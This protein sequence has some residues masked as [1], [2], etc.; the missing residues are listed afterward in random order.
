MTDGL[1]SVRIEPSGIEGIAVLHWEFAYDS[2]GGFARTFC[3]AELETAGLHF[4]VVQANVS[5]SIARRTLRGMHL[6]RPPHGEPKIVSC[7]RGRIWLAAVDM[8]SDSP[9]CRQ[10]RA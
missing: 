10:W 2:R 3:R 1:H 5:R 7:A 4:D 9:T 6:Q 8:R